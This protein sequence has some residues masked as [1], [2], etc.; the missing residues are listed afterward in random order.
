MNS[1]DNETVIEY[2]RLK[3]Y[4]RKLGSVAVAFSAGVDST[5]LLKAAVDAL[6]DKVIAI[7]ASSAFYPEREIAEAVLFCKDNGVR[8]IVLSFDEFSV[9]GMA[10]N[11]VNRCYLCKRNLFQKII[12]T[13]SAEGAEYVLEGSNADDE[14]DYRPG[15][16]AVEELGVISPLRELKF[17]KALIREISGILDLPTF[18]KP[19]FAC[20]A[21]RIPYGEEITKEKLAMIDEAEQILMDM[22]YKQV[23]VRCHGNLARIEVDPA[24][25]ESLVSTDVRSE[26]YKEF[27]KLGF[28]YVTLDIRGYRL[29]SLNEVL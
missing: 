14:G 20:L 27:K 17:T 7:T 8:H 10:S 25:I 28:T 4:I 15:L 26:I 12:E 16:K 13:A 5:F 22:G 6:G 24:D 11:P 29:G 1:S 21:S 2:E 9:E 18:N 19:S 3:D 23:R